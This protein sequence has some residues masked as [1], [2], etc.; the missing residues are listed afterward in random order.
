MKR[1]LKLFVPVVLIL[2]LTL[3]GCNNSAKASRKK[4]VAEVNGEKILLGELL[5]AYDSQKESYGITEEI[6][7]DEQYKEDILNMKK[8]ILENLIYE[9]L[10]RQ[11]SEE[12][13]FK[14]TDE[15]MKEAKEQFNTM[16]TSL[17]EQMKAAETSEGS[18]KVDY[19][20]K[21]KEYVDGQL[22]TI[23][24]TQDEYIKMMA[25]QIATQKFVD[26]TIGVV[27]VD[28]DEIKAYYDEQLKAQREG[29]APSSEELDFYG[30]PSVTVKHI[31]IA[32]PKEEQDEYKKLVGESKT[33]EA[34]KYLEEK[35]KGIYPKAKEVLDKA[36]KGDNFEKLI[37]EYGEDP[38]MKDNDEGYIVKKDG[39]FI[40][41]FESTS[42][43]L[44]VGKI[45]DLVGGPFG[46]HIIKAYKITGET[47]V[48]LE[49]RAAAIKQTLES[50]KENEKWNSSL[51]GWMKEAKVTKYEDLI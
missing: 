8:G 29:Q 35:L 31:L 14:V 49:E 39:K 4:V 7:K 40:P 21:A 3:T 34:K 27:Q 12:A 51:D 13:G 10:V 37:E 38:G 32:L 46:Y 30:E 43:G 9:K 23:G 18:E 26:K 2:A 16:M 42:L 36:K 28:E 20:A 45:S 47:V 24:K 25:E 50:E 15:T 1:I 41:E 17:E 11:K 5:D 22:K 48:S 44:K 33:E 6:E 19:A